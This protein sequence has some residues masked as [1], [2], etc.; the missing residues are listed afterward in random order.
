MKKISKIALVL[1]VIFSVVVFSVS[2]AGQAEQEE[3]ASMDYPTG[4]ITVY[5]PFSA[6]GSTDLMARIIADPLS[7]KLGVPLVVEN[8]PGGG[9][10]IAMNALAGAK[11]DG[12]T[13]ALTSLGPAMLTPN[14]GDV[15]YTDE[16]FAPISQTSFLPSMLF[17]SSESEYET[18]EEL[19]AAAKERYGE[20]TYSSTGAGGTGHVACE[21]FQEEL[22][23]K[24][25]FNMV[26]FD[27]GT[28]ATTAVL[29]GHIEFSLGDAGD[30]ADHVA[31]GNLRVLAIASEERDPMFPDVPTFRELGY[32]V[33]IGPW[34]GFAAPAGT[35]EDVLAILDDAI[36]ETLALPEVVSQMGNINSPVV[37]TE[38]T[39]F[40]RKWHQ[41][42]AMYRTMIQAIRAN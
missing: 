13:I 32:D 22:G 12:Y 41:D 35:P 1:T 9:G 28:E 18:L 33:V 15:G 11:P 27:S 37:Y 19:I 42:F 20:M 39:P 30:T 2:G 38:T 5:V 34:W 23:E 8:R 21:L 17:V 26:P 14:Q 4:N 7:D 10:A 16:E 6:G 3:A 36:K 31:D 29:G 24:G 40:T 25:L